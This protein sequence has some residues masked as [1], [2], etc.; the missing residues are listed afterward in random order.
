MIY[1]ALLPVDIRY[2]K[3]ARY[4]AAL[5]SCEDK[6]K[7]STRLESRFEPMAKLLAESELASMEK[8]L[9]IFGNN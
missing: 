9:Q 4:Y 8:W 1:I 6:E 5:V 3:C 7:Y 2:E